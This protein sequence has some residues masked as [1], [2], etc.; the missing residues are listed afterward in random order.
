MSQAGGGASGATEFVASVA[1]RARSRRTSAV[2][3]R[4]IAGSA[5]RARREG[6]TGT[7]TEAIGQVPESAAVARVTN[8][9]IR[10]TA[11]VTSGVNALNTSVRCAALSIASRTRT[12]ALIGA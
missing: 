2:R 6:G 8:G 10:W 9:N 12:H 3:A 5:V 4:D 7:E 1:Q 11:R